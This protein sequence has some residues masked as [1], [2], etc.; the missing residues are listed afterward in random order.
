MLHE[1]NIVDKLIEDLSEKQ[2]KE[3]DKRYIAITTTPRKIKFIDRLSIDSRYSALAHTGGLS[4]PQQVIMGFFSLFELMDKDKTYK[5]DI[6]EILKKRIFNLYENLDLPIPDSKG[7]T[8][9]YSLINIAQIA[10]IKYSEKFK[11]YL[12]DKVDFLEYLFKLANEKFIVCLPGD[13]FAGPKWSLRVSLANLDVEDY[14]VIGKA[15]IDIL[16][17]FYKDYKKIV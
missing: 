5:K 16:E 8:Y 6:H 10:R 11:D 1:K 2:K 3:I 17:E 9:Y 13:G 15:L 7:N 4:C 14:I 12:I